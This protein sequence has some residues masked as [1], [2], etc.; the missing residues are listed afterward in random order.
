MKQL[1]SRVAALVYL[2]PF[3]GVGDVGHPSADEYAS[4]TGAIAASRAEVYEAQGGRGD[5]VVLGAGDRVWIS[6]RDHTVTIERQAASPEELRRI[7]ELR[8]REGW[9]RN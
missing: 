1:N 2:L 5:A 8:G 9:R 6:E 4:R 7:G 3:L